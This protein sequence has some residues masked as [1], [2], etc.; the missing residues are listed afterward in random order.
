MNQPDAEKPV[1]PEAPA[2]RK[3]LS[4]VKNSLL[5]LGGVSAVFAL[6]LM[7]FG[8]NRRPTHVAAG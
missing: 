8:P 4:F 5:L 1:Q 2:V 6:G 7:L 3:L